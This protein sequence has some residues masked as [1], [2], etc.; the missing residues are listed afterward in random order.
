MRRTGGPTLA[1]FAV[2]L[3]LLLLVGLL[4]GCGGGG[5]DDAACVIALGAAADRGAVSGSDVL[6]TREA[7]K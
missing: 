4:G 7:C 5:D 6:A 2:V 1:E 3:L